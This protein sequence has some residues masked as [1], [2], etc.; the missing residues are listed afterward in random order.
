MFSTGQGP[1][2]LANPSTSTSGVSGAG[3]RFGD[4]FGGPKIVTGG[5]GLTLP[6]LV[7]VGGVGFLAF[8]LWGSKR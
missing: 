3:A 1:I 8:A 5:A 4:I 6:M 2:N 7:A